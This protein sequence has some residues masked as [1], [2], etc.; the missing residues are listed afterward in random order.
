MS[1]KSPSLTVLIPTFNRAAVLRETLDALL[2][3]ER[4]GLDCRIVVIDN[5]STDDT[6]GVVRSFQERLPLQLLRETRP[7]KNCA[8]NKALREC[9]L[10]EIVV[11]TDD[12]VT[13]ARDWFRQ[14]TAATSRWPDT[15]VFGGRLEVVW[16][17][18]QQPEWAVT[19]WVQTFGYCKHHY[20][21]AETFYRPP[22][23]PYGGNYWVRR[24]VFQKVPHFNVSIGPKPKD[25]IM[26]SETSFLM[27]VHRAGLKMM[28]CPTAVVQHRIQEKECKIPALR[29]RGFTFG[30][31]Q[32]RLHGWH[33]S[34][35]YARSK[36][37]W[38]LTLM[39]DYCYT[40]IRFLFGWVLPDSRRNCE[41]TVGCM[42][43][44][45]QLSE[46]RRLAWASFRSGGK[47]AASQA[48]DPRVA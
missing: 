19:D 6:A 33:R 37:L 31:G 40:A 39:A 34:K 41:I 48:P 2:R 44:F 38:T 4:T 29:R 9:A 20:A 26:G 46:T 18:N 32:V 13:P 7:G 36:T 23:C 8:L 1:D 16:P 11:F 28:Y 5:N 45:G 35:L 12:D 17:N 47:D 3:V 43:R 24:S 27:D 22:D 15:S 10:A 14:I 21:E 30:R 25:R 42:I